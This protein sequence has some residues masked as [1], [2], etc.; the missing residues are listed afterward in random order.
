MKT[1]LGYEIYNKLMDKGLIAYEPGSAD[2][3]R[4]VIEAVL[5]SW[6]VEI[7]WISVPRK[8]SK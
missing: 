1:K 7:R 5:E 2:A 3:A 4:D 6:G 8:R